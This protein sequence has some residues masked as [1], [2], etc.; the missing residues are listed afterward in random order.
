MAQ[1]TVRVGLVG[2]GFVGS[3][4][5]LAYNNVS[6]VYG[7]QL[8][9][10]EQVRLFDI[11]GELAAEGASRLG[12]KE[13]TDDW[14][15]ITRAPD[16]DLVDIV[17]PNY[18]HAEIAIDAAAHGKHIYCEKPLAHDAA[19]GRQM[20]EAVCQAGVVHLVSFVY[21]M[22][23]AVAFAKELIDAGKIGRIL[24]YHGQYLHDFALDPNVPLTWRFDAKKAGTG[25][26]SDIG[27]HTIDIARY[28]VGEVVRVFA[29]SRTLIKKRPLPSEENLVFGG[30]GDAISESSAYGEVD[31]DDVTQMLVEFEGGVI[32]MIET[33]W[34]AA[35]HSNELSFEVSGE[36]GAIKFNWAHPNE[37]QV[38]FADDPEN[39][40]GFRTVL[41]GPTH[42]GAE[43]FGPLP[44]LGM[45]YREAFY[46]ALRE[47]LESISQNRT[48]MPNFLDGLRACE[49]IDAAQRASASGTWEDVRFTPI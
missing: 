41:I 2:A 33:S 5:S 45:G 21:R 30:G 28:L 39:V 18:A 7:Q 15:K 40:S 23:P 25:S 24:H 4:H 27:S 20:Y 16:I 8:P 42:P 17:T 13:G 12:W 38:Q 9:K 10:V 31:V 43:P 29:Q 19:S 47:L 14:R 46:I 32:G 49:V 11:T 34:V 44:G 37:I 35:G 26:L 3:V 48:A 22:C 36:R 6:M 1:R